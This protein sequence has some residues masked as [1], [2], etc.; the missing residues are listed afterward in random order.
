[1]IIIAIRFVDYYIMGTRFLDLD[2]R[3]Q[4]PENANSDDVQL[5]SF[6]A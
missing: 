4:R 2:P 5:R 6:F 1:M 3:L